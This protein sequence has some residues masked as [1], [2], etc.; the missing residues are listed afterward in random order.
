MQIVK[1]EHIHNNKSLLSCFFVAEVVVATS[2]KGFLVYNKFYQMNWIV[3][4]AA[5][6]FISTLLN[7]FIFVQAL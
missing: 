2:S 6:A 5:T 4:K 7:Q 1:T 3:Y